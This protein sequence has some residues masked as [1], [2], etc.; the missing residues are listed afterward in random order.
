M[1]RRAN[2]PWLYYGDEPGL[3]SRVLQTD[4]VP[5]NFSFRGANKVKIKN[6]LIIKYFFPFNSIIIVL[7]MY[8]TENVIIDAIFC[9]FDRTLTLI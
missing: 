1:F 4:P 7:Y 8:I 3:A 9:V 6:N 2:L 5:I